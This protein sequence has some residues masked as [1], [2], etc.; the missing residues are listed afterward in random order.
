MNSI[1]VKIKRLRET[2]VFPEYATEGSAALDL[3]SC[4]DL[5]LTIQPGERALV[6]TGLA[7]EPEGGGVAAILCARSGLAT[8]H[9]LAL[10][11]GIG[12]IDSDYRGEIL[13]SMIN[14]GNVP[15]TINPGERIAQLMFIP[16]LYA[17]VIKTEALTDTK[18]GAGGFGST[19]KD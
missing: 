19:G 8:K 5:P 15:Y 17:Q 2:S 11:N 1:K 9:G 13:V 7:I 10:A 3:H 16:I 18:R 4:A 6:P 12:V 14:N